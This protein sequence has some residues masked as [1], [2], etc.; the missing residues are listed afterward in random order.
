MFYSILTGLNPAG[1]EDSPVSIFGCHKG[2]GYLISISTY[3]KVAFDFSIIGSSF[4]SFLKD[5]CHFNSASSIC[6][7]A[8][9]SSFSFSHCHFLI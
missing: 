5:S 4:C 6:F 8:K 3:S 2:G 9:S 1:I 7:A